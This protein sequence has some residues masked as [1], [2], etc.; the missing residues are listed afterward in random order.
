LSSQR[1]AKITQV[2]TST[3]NQFIDSYADVAN[4]NVVDLQVDDR[5]IQEK[6][7][8]SSET[9]EQLMVAALAYRDLGK[10][11]LSISS[12]LDKEAGKLKK[13][14]SEEELAKIKKMNKSSVNNSGVELVK[15][16]RDY[17]KRLIKFNNEFVLDEKTFTAMLNSKMMQ[18]TPNRKLEALMLVSS[19]IKNMSSDLSDIAVMVAKEAEKKP[20]EKTDTKK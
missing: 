14:A 2:I 12:K 5:T 18:T 10:T 6:L 15:K 8:S 11:L 20:S 13:K 4:A 7:I 9:R 16:H 17:F 19:I 1:K 3:L